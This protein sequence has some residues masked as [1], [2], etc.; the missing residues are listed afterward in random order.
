MK[1]KTMIVL[2]VVA[3]LVTA[4]GAQ[5]TPTASPTEA[6]AGM[7]NPASK[8]CVDQGYQSEIRDEAGGQVGYCLFPDGSECEEWA[9]Y[10]GECAPGSESQAAPP[11]LAN[12]A[13]ENCLAQGGT[14]SI[15]T[16]EDGGQYGICLFEDNLQCEE[17]ALLRGECPLGGVKVTGYVTTAAVYCAITGGDYAVTG[18]SGAEDEQGTCTFKDGSQCDAWGYYNG[19]CVPGSAPAAGA[20]STI[21]PLPVE[22]CDGQAQAMS[23][24]LD[25]LIPTQSEEPLDDPI[26]SAKGTGCQAAITGTGVQFESPAAAVTALGSMLE[27]QGWIVDPMLQADGPTGTGAGYRKGDQICLAGA[28]WTPDDS[29]NCPKDQ[30]ISACEVKPE[31]QNYTVTLNCGVETTGG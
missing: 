14:V 13:S 20:A 30:P 21:R 25:D 2:I 7:A 9:F 23:H 22:V 28:M 6:A 10:R 18:N 8:F 31:Q 5:P 27:E 11:Q 12:P 4:C 17:W 24:A 29:A 3:V 16:R 1:Q 19:K 26:T 15:Q